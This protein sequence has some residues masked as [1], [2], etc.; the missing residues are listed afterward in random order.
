[1]ARYD[2]GHDRR[3]RQHRQARPR[4]ANYPPPANSV[5]P[6]PPHHWLRLHEYLPNRVAL[7]SALVSGGFAESAAFA[8]RAAQDGGDRLAA[9]ARAYRAYAPNIRI[10]AG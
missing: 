9:V 8:E 5:G 10:F 6:R 4:P 3:P 1:N 7:E 2:P